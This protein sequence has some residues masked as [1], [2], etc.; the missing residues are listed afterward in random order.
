MNTRNNKKGQFYQNK[1][2]SALLRL[3]HQDLALEQLTVTALCEEAKVNRST[4]YSHYSIPK[5]VLDEIEEETLRQT[6]T[7]LKEI[8]GNNLHSMTLLLQ[9]IKEHDDVFRVLFLQSRE[10]SFLEK[11]LQYTILD[12]QHL[13]PRYHNRTDY[14]YVNAFIMGGSRE[15]L[16]YWIA[17]KYQRDEK[18]VA[19]LI[20]K[21]NEDAIHSFLS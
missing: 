21:I 9:Y 10:I 19:A 6:R 11:L 20:I 4:F 16:N 18:E 14:E 2:K 8:S 13:R 1:L 3:M 5:D 12:L 17:S 7:F 15:I